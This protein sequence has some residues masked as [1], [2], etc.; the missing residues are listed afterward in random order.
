M[1]DALNSLGYSKPP[2]ATRVVVAM[3]ARKKI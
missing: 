3:R 1:D 2:R